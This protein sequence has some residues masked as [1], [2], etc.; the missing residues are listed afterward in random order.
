M[1][2]KIKTIQNDIFVDTLYT[3]LHPMSSLHLQPRESSQC[4]SAAGSRSIMSNF[5]STVKRTIT[6]GREADS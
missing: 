1:L 6:S 4:K 2:E 3:L 5:H